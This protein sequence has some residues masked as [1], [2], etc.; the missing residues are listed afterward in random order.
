M[1]PF[2]VRNSTPG[3]VRRLLLPVSFGASSLS[4]LQILDGHLNNQKARS[5][6]AGFTLH[7][8]HVDDAVSDETTDCVQKL[9]Q[10]QHLFPAYEYST[11]RLSEVFSAADA[12]QITRGNETSSASQSPSNSQAS[13]ELP[14]SDSLIKLL[15]SLPSATSRVDVIA[16]L[17]TRLIV[18]HAKEL[19]CES[20]LW[21]DSTTRLAEKTLAESAKGRG[22][23]IPWQLADG[24]GPHEIEFLFPLQELLR[25]ELVS[26]VDML[27]S[28]LSLLLDTPTSTLPPSVTSKSTAIDDL[29][30]QYFESVEKNYP[31]IVANVVRTTRKLKPLDFPA[32]LRRCRLCS[33]PLLNQS[34]GISDQRNH[35]QDS[36]ESFTENT[37]PS[38]CYG[39]TT[40]VPDAAELLP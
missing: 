19:G 34:A 7:V 9:E 37:K 8:F 39:C 29:M 26:Y 21:G 36:S 27:S 14:R 28:P 33:M 6:R 20:V 17:R 10:L 31:S 15:R 38:L 11:S 2:R 5:G 40:I 23:S 12:E 4:L 24:C 32:D 25:K 30:K 35:E 3:T 16:T 22:L 13:P 18:R 1:D